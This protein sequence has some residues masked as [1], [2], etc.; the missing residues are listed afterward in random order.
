MDKL[1]ELKLAYAK[2]GEEIEKLKEQPKGV[3][4]PR[5]G[6]A[7]YWIDSLG[8][9]CRNSSH[10]ISRIRFH[11]VYQTL[12]QV[13]KAATLMRQSNRIIQACL[14][15]DPDYVPDWG[16][17]KTKY[18]VFYAYNQ[19]NWIVSANTYNSGRPAYVSTLGIAQSI[20]DMFN[21]KDK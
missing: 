16:S 20:C 2:M 4:E 8:L 18:S 5:G 15:F 1:S 9:V 19:K 21:A 6:E 12:G 10:P 7:F 13:Q 17:R 11:T 14:D 3:W